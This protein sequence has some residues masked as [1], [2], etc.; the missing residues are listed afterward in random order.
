MIVTKPIA[1]YI[2]ACYRESADPA[3]RVTWSEVCPECGVVPTWVN[4]MDHVIVIAGGTDELPGITAVI[5]AC[6]GYLVV[7]PSSLGLGDSF[8][9]WTN[10]DGN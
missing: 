4:D 7:D 1:D 2:S 6:E 10:A 3:T 8:P 5:I 9:G